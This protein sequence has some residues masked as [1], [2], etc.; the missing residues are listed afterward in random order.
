MASASDDA[1][2]KVADFGLAKLLPKGAMMKTACGTPGYVA[3]EI[4]KNKGY[5]GG[6]CDLW[7]T[8]VILYVLLCGF[9]PF[10]DEDLN[11]LF[12]DIMQAKYDFPSPY[13][14]KI[15]QGARSLVE[16]LLVVDVSKRL[17][18]TQAL[19]HK[20]IKE[21]AAEPALPE[22]QEQLRKYNAMRKFKKAAQV[23]MAVEVMR[24]ISKAQ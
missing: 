12:K 6:G 16:G 14:D 1:S 22:T 5:A 20:W 21:A 17:T 10:Y 18:A 23:V 11:A 7:S 2:I 3:P 19:Q 13:W 9:P 24:H 15:S 4:L 8:G